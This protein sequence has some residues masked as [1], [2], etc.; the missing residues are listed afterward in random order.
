MGLHSLMP[1]ELEATLQK[2]ARFFR[3]ITVKCWE[4]VSSLGR[5]Q[6][7]ITQTHNKEPSRLKEF[8]LSKD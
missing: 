4:D 3:G 1:E 7:Q 2:H 5:V 8:V 6:D